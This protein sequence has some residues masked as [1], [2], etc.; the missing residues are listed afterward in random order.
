[1]K[2]FSFLFLVVIFA[3]FFSFSQA[4]AQT[5]NQIHVELFG[6]SLGYS[7]GYAYFIKPNLT[8][9]IGFGY[10]SNGTRKDEEFGDSYFRLMNI[11]FTFTYLLGQSK[12][13]MELYTGLRFDKLETSV[14][15]LK[16]DAWNRWY[17]VPTAGIGYRFMGKHFFGSLTAGIVRYHYLN[18]NNDVEWLFIPGLKF[19][20][21]I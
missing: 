17:M 14:L 11:P 8:A 9:S 6:G 16:P 20:Y 13:K 21:R 18:E 12:H 5:N 2:P 19:G 4:Q 10:L 3:A 7:L 1:M 15:D